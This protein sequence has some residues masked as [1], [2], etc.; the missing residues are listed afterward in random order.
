VYELSLDPKAKKPKP[1]KLKPLHKGSKN[2]ANDLLE[3]D[4][5]KKTDGLTSN[6][7]LDKEISDY[8]DTNKIFK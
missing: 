3:S 6:A 2:M 5:P 4:K 1:T 7:D 8:L